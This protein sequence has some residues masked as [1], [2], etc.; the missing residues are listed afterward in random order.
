MILQSSLSWMFPLL[1][2]VAVVVDAQ[3]FPH[4]NFRNRHPLQQHRQQQQPTP[5]SQAS[6]LGLND[7]TKQD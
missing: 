6:V 4:E 7:M 5:L 2:V 3:Q 1:T